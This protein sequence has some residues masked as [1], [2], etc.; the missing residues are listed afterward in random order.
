LSFNDELSRTVDVKSVIIIDIVD[1]FWLAQRIR[2]GI[3]YWW[4]W[5]SLV[6]MT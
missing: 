6:T 4:I 2:C 5:T 3:E 1:I